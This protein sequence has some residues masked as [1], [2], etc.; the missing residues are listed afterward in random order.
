MSNGIPMPRAANTIWKARDM[1]ISERAKKKSLMLEYYDPSRIQ[2]PSFAAD[3]G[4]HH[5]KPGRVLLLFGR[6]LNRRPRAP[7]R[8]NMLRTDCPQIRACLLYTS[9]SPRDGL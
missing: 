1:A 8:P 7:V 9:P 5:F 2:S 3:S 4:R 6:A